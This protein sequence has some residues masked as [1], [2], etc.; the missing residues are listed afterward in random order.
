MR[1][2]STALLTSALVCASTG[3]T[4]A[5]SSSASPD[6]AGQRIELPGYGVSVIVPEHWTTDASGNSGLALYPESGFYED[7]YV[8][9]TG[10][11]EAQQCRLAASS[12]A[13][14]D[15]PADLATVLPAS[16]WDGFRL[17]AGD[18]LNGRKPPASSPQLRSR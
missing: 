15:V 9:A 7:L 12:H 17:P 5:Q 2:L 6:A 11:P 18:A 13:T 14:C 4:A 3:L 10:G 1:R 8:V 16:D